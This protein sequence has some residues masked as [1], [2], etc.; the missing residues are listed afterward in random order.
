MLPT[1]PLPRA[2]SA[3]MHLEM[4][5]YDRCVADAG[6]EIKART[7][8]REAQAIGFTGPPFVCDGIVRPDERLDVKTVMVGATHSRCSRLTSIR[9]CVTDQS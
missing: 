9:S 3:D 2:Y 6:A 4:S 8:I 1:R 5:R 7:N